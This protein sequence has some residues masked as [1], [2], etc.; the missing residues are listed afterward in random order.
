MIMNDDDGIDRNALYK[1]CSIYF[2]MII[3]SNNKQQ[4]WLMVKQKTKS[5]HKKYW[6]TFRIGVSSINQKHQAS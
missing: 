4:Q 1:S 5:K 2:I 3:A 6:I